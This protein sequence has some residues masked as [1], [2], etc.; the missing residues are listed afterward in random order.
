MCAECGMA[1]PNCSYCGDECYGACEDPDTCPSCWPVKHFEHDVYD[2]DALVDC[3]D[4]LCRCLCHSAMY[5]DDGIRFEAGVIFD[6]ESEPS[7]ERTGVFPFFKV[8]TAYLGS[9]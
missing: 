5:E 6:E 9:L 2:E 7:Y 8:S 4:A 3:L 1:A